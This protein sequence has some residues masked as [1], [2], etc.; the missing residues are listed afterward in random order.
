MQTKKEFP[1]HSSNSTKQPFHG[2]RKRFCCS[3]WDSNLQASDYEADTLPTVLTRQL[4]CN[5][6]P[7]VFSSGKPR[8]KWSEGRQGGEEKLVCSYAKM[9]S[10]ISFF[11]YPAQMQMSLVNASWHSI[12]CPMQAASLQGVCWRLQC[13]RNRTVAWLKTNLWCF[14]ST[15]QVICLL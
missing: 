3:V 1:C 9:Q 4:L 6:P 13:S 10:L 2:K 5:I 11:L 15:T 14:S 7:V 12:P 8:C